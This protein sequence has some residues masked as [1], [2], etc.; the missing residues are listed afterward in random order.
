MKYTEK[1]LKKGDKFICI[2]N[3]NEY[4][5]WSKGKIYDVKEGYNG[6]LY[7][8]NDYGTSIEVKTMLRYHNINSDSPLKFVLIKEENN[9][10][11]FK[12][13]DLVE[14]IKNSMYARNEFDEYY[15][16]GDKAIVT[17]V[18][19]VY[20][21]LGDNMTANIIK[22]D[23]IKKV[24]PTPELTDHEEKLVLRLAE[25]IQ[26]KD[27]RLSNIQQFKNS[28]KLNEEEIEKIS[29]EIKEITKKLLTK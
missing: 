6:I 29:K 7:I 23:E 21:H 5:W 9:M 8:I 1:M 15:K 2:E 4:N 22:K 18:G 10:K 20:V 24:E 28:I 3:K 25:C 17:G 14:V 16:K 26:T 13:G 19:E 27:D 12:V 11:E